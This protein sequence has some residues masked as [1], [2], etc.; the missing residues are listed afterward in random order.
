MF[1]LQYIGDEGLF[2]DIPVNGNF[3]FEKGDII[4]VEKVEDANRLL[5]QTQHFTL[6]NP[7]SSPLS[8]PAPSAPVNNQPTA[9]PTVNETPK[10]PVEN[11]SN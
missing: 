4:E 6:I 9:P 7:T 3:A 5:S 11:P 2:L 10:D 8:Q 1:T